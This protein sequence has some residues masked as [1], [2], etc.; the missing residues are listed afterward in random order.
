LA[1]AAVAFLSLPPHAAVVKLT[2]SNTAMAALDWICFITT[3]LP[4]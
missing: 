4:W 2:A 3:F 1:A